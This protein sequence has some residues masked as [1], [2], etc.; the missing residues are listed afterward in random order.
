M[1][2]RS[3]LLE[4]LEDNGC[5]VEMEDDYGQWFRNCVNSHSCVVPHEEAFSCTSCCHI[6][7]E[8]RIPATDDLDSDYE[9]YKLFLIKVIDREEEEV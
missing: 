9:I 6:F 5:F 3:V 7:H 4:H 2:N 8:L 1:I